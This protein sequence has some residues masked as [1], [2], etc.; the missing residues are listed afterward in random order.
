MKCTTFRFDHHSRHCIVVWRLLIWR[1][2]LF[3]MYCLLFY[4]K[5]SKIGKGNLYVTK[6]RF[7]RN[8]ISCTEDNQIYMNKMCAKEF[9]DTNFLIKQLLAKYR[10]FKKLPKIL[11][12]HKCCN[13]KTIIGCFIEQLLPLYIFNGSSMRGIFFSNFV[14]CEEALIQKFLITWNNLCS[15]PLT[16]C[17]YHIDVFSSSSLT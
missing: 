8:E 9:S 10:F 5:K 6:N 11:P 7:D 15:N 17:H 16:N 1:S 14:S 12:I 13:F 3:H 2:A 4:A